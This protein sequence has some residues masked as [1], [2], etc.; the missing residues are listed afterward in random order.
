MK[1]LLTA[2]VVFVMLFIVSSISIME[3][4]PS[5]PVAPPAEV[6]GSINAYVVL[7]NLET[8]EKTHLT[9]S[10]VEFQ[11]T[12][13]DSFEMVNAITYEVGVPRQMLSNSLSPDNEQSSFFPSVAYANE[14]KYKCDSTS[15]VCATLTFYYQDGYQGQ[16]EWMY[17]QKV[18]TV[19]YRQDS[20]VSWSNGVIGAKCSA[21][22]FNQ[23][24]T[25][26]ATVSG[27]VSNPTSGSAYEIV[28][29]FAGSNNK[30]LVNEINYQLASQSIDLHRGSS[31]WNF[32]FCIVNGGGSVIYGCY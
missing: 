31:N 22:W 19:W 25:C 7:E 12:L 30:T 3:A 28:P 18:R 13:D 14:Q 26:S 9:P 2:T 17:S 10:F 23:G 11:E 1:K 8:G 27:S 5:M 24:G 20:Q 4:Q 6:E 21:E 29:W 16:D 15:S 32:Y